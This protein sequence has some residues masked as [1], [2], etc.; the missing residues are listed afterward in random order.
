MNKKIIRFLKISLITVLILCVGVFTFLTWFMIRESDK[1]ITSV[2]NTYMEGVNTQL[3][4][5]FE[6]LVEMRLKQIE[7]I[8]QATPPESVEKLDEESISRLTQQALSE[9]IVYMALYNTEGESEVLYG[10]DVEIMDA[11]VFLESMNNAEK[12]VTT[13]TTQS[14]ETLLLYGISV[15]YPY[16]TGYPMSDGSHCTAMVV[17]IPIG[18]LNEALSLGLDDTMVFSHIIRKDGMFVVRNGGV[19]AENYYDWIMENAPESEET[20]VQEHLGQMQGAIEERDTFSM[21]VT[22]EGESRHV[23]CSPLS[24]TDWTMITVM[25]YGTL[26]DAVASLGARRILIGLGGCAA[27]L[28]AMLA[29]FFGYFRLSKKQMA[30]LDQAKKEAEYANQAKSEFLANMSHDIRT[31]MNAIVGMTAIATANINKTDQVRD[32][33]KKITLSSRHLLGLINDVLDMSKIESGKLTLNMD[34]ISLREVME[35]I[36]SIVQ[37]QINAKKQVF[38]IFI[39]NIIEEKVYGDGLR[40]NQILI[41]LLSNAMKFTP[42]GGRIDVSVSQEPSPLGADF[43]RTHFV[44][45]DTGIGMTPEFQK[46]IF[47]SFVREDNERIQ[48][49]EGSGL[50]MTIT[51]YIV[52]AMGGTIGV[53]SEP[54][55]GS[56]FHIT[57]DMQYPSRQEE[58]MLLPKWEILVVDDD[59]QICTGASESLREIGLE[60]EWTTSGASAV[61]MVAERHSRKKDYQIILID[62]KMPGMDGI[63][64]ARKIRAQVGDEVP[65]L[66][67]SAYDWSGIEEE[68]RSAGVNG[69]VSKPLFKSTLYYG[70]SRFG[71]EMSESEET[72]TGGPGNL[73]GRNILLAEDNELNREIA[74]ELL[75]DCGLNITCAGNGQECADR[76]K[77]SETGHYDAVLMDLRMPVMNGYEAAKAIRSCGR[78]DADVPII[79]MTA[80]AF[81][82]D[83]RRCMDCGMNAHT[84]KP[85]DMKELL[86]LLEKEITGRAKG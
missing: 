70:L 72:N 77:E 31:P 37:P 22:V 4:R 43:V 40:L 23:Y 33:L 30:A 41:N 15:G 9:D 76:F 80:D 20:E 78:A 57:L 63:E 79:A 10:G 84:A 68:A 47:E 61:E 13:G 7:G 35:S 25:P 69:F 51:K 54:E 2:A 3:Q 58:Q 19:D 6:T 14:G 85:L 42:E 46:R 24:F 44:V 50:G 73:K 56:R 64:T 21:V 65:I 59:E 16:D 52:D 45:E 82:E 67:I 81:A 27:I 55:K 60:A 49:I 62:W 83:I 48:K 74:C 5:H 86:R 18:R 75:S 71:K 1:T 28:A 36:V 8:V 39:N 17:G 34:I 11:D 29:V 32:C 38:D 12:K 66:L 26:D 53:E